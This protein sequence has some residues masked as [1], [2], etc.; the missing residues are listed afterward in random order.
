MEAELQRA[1][2][3]LMRRYREE[4]ELPADEILLQRKASRPSA[5]KKVAVPLTGNCDDHDADFYSQAL[6]GIEPHLRQVADPPGLNSLVLRVSWPGDSALRRFPTGAFISSADHN[7]LALYVG[8]YRPIF[9][10]AGFYLVY[11]AWANSVAVVPQLPSRS[12]NVF[13]HCN[14]GAGVAVLRHNLP[15]DYILVELLP[16]QDNRGLISTSATFCMWWS[17]GPA[18]GRWIQKEVVLPLPSEPEEDSSQPD[19]NFCA[20]TIFTA[21]TNCL[22]WVDLLQGIL[23][24]DHVL[25]HHPEFRF[26]ALPW[27]CS[28]NIKPD[29][30]GGRGMPDQYRSMRCVRRGD[31]HIIKFISM[32][33]HGQGADISDVA[34]MIWTLD[35][36]DPMSKWKAGKTSFRISDL[37]CD[38]IYK[39]E[40]PPRTPSCPVVSLVQDDVIYITVEDMLNT[41]ARGPCMLSLDMNKHRVL[42]AFMPPPRSRVYPLP[43]IFASTFTTYL[44][45]EVSG[46]KQCFGSAR[47]NRW[48]IGGSGRNLL[49]F[50]P[51][52]MLWR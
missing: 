22:C 3:E 47:K 19:Y 8:P 35:P 18:A 32:H 48:E 10:G 46:V 24:C 1:T 26:V 13:S 50:Q 31:E 21:G 15:S 17:S 16:R 11:D 28:V 39:R 23:I 38:P 52:A 51:A 20:D 25:D 37:W 33:G 45:K 6:D 14:I 41:E 29:P 27:E 7:L 34:L 30:E 4:V 44:N 12:I 43:S 40:L 36:C 9:A 2:K 5:V 49:C 42:S